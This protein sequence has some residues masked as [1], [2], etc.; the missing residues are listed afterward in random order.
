MLTSAAAM[1]V[2]ELRSARP[3]SAS[4][5]SKLFSASSRLMSASSG[6]DAVG[7]SIARTLYHARAS[8]TSVFWTAQL[9]MARMLLASEGSDVSFLG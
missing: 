7:F 2:N 6:W 8:T 9:K 4:T 1:S 3:K 5:C